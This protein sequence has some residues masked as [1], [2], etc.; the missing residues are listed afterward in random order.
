MARDCVLEGAGEYRSS[1]SLYRLEHIDKRFYARKP[2]NQQ[3][4][5]I[6]KV[7]DIVYL[8]LHEDT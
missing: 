6:Q 3:F 4:S 5:S 8:G 1:A 7:D 2:F